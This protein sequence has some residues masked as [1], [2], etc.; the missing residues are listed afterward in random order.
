MSSSEG[1]SQVTRKGNGGSCCM[2]CKQTSFL[3]CFF[4][5]MLLLQCS[6]SL[7]VSVVQVY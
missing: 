6:D 2:K 7:L 4:L 5:H 1:D 3:F